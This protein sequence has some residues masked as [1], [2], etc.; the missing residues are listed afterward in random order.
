MKDLAQELLKVE[1]FS[2]QVGL[3]NKLATWVLRGTGSMTGVV[4]SLSDGHDKLR[5]SNV[6]RSAFQLFFKL[7]M[8]KVASPPNDQCVMLKG[9]DPIPSFWVTSE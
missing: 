4:G 8:P 9:P 3:M 5:G 1:W 2:A 7:D 6:V